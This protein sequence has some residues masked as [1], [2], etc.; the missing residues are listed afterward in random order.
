M[1]D[2]SFLEQTNDVE[3]SKKKFTDYFPLKIKTD[4]LSLCVFAHFKEDTFTVSSIVRSASTF[5]STLS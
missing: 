3:T 4:E 1:V 5:I 2:F